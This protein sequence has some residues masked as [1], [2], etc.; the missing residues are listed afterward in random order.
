M[1]IKLEEEKQRALEKM[2]REATEKRLAE[3]DGDM[4][5]MQLQEDCLEQYKRDMR[6]ALSS[7]NDFIS[8]S[9]LNT[10]HE[11]AKQKAISKVRRHFGIKLIGCCQQPQ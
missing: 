8:Q 1:K 2:Q 10:A 4:K 6:N 3:K 7:S 9:D 5:N 11:A